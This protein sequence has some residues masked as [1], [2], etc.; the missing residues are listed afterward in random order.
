M[1]GRLVPGGVCGGGAGWTKA[2]GEEVKK[3]AAAYRAKV[4]AI[5]DRPRAKPAKAT[6]QAK[7]QPAA[8]EAAKPEADK[9]GLSE[10]T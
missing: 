5:P 6:D 9:A 1:I 7:K 2:T 10:P 3:R 8:P 4:D